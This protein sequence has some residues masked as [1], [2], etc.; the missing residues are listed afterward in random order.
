MAK[1]LSARTAT[2]DNAVVANDRGNIE[3]RRTGI[4]EKNYGRNRQSRLE[5]RGSLGL[6]AST[7]LEI[8]FFEKCSLSN[9]QNK[10]TNDELIIKVTF[11]IG[12]GIP[13]LTP[14][15]RTIFI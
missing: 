8:S 3:R 6:A 15:L 5:E 1:L 12:H 13:I 11:W 4:D 10:R 14:L 2:E 7:G 9:Y